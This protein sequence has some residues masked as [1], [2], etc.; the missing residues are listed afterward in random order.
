MSLAPQRWP[1]GAGPVLEIARPKPHSKWRPLTLGGLVVAVAAVGAFLLFRPDPCDDTDFTSEAFGYCLT[2]PDGWTAEPALFGGEVRLDQFAPTQ[3]S[4]TVI[5]EAVD[6]EEGTDLGQW[7]TF[8][9]QG[10]SDAGLVPGPAS[11]TVV[12]GMAA[13]QWDLTATSDTGTDYRMREVVIVRDEIG[14][15]ITLNDTE[16]RFDVSA[17]SLE[18][19]LDSWR[20]H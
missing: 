6:L 8:V 14:W 10:D 2:V 3:A 7:A 1:E 19:M 15:R 4:T 9:R 12:D 13:Q 16:E 5:V 11:E 17:V 18:G 20:F